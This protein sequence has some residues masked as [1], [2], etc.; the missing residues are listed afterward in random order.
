MNIWLSVL[1][2]LLVLIYGAVRL[3]KPPFVR[4]S[5]FEVERRAKEGDARAVLQRARVRIEPFV[6]TLRDLLSLIV[7]LGINGAITGLLTSGWTAGFLTV[8]LVLAVAWLER[9]SPLKRAGERLYARIEPRL[10]GLAAGRKYFFFLPI[11][12]V[13]PDK[14]IESEAELLHLLDTSTFLEHE[15]RILIH[16]ALEF[17][18]LSVS[19]AMSSRRSIKSVDKGDV[20]G[21]LVLDELYKTGKQ[22]FIVTDGGLDTVVGILKLER[23]TSLDMKDTP[24]ALKA[25]SPEVHFIDADSPI[26]DGLGYLRSSKA[27]FLV[28]QNSDGTTAG[29]LTLDN[30]LRC[31]FEAS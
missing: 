10:F 5:R 16:S 29:L 23:L 31:L 19:D 20:L 11:P 6:R 18:G 30:I 13:E 27:P 12:A 15:R 1:L 4:L 14:R 21:P 8:V 25:M 22:A 28:V 7:V 24:T 26:T 9:W 3:A 2:G 17:T